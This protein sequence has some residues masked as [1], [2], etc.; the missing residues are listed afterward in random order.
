MTGILGSGFGLYGYLPAVVR[1]G[2]EKVVL[3]SKAREVFLRRPE[4]QFCEQ[5]I[6]WV[7]DVRDLM[8]KSSSV[9]FAVTPSAQSSYIK[10]YIPT[11]K[12]D[13]VILEKPIGVSPTEAAI[14]LSLLAGNKISTRIGYTFLY[15]QW[16]QETIRYLRNITAGA[17][18]TL[19]WNFLAHHYKND[20]TS[21]K[22]YNREG[23][24]V[25]RFYGTQVL[26][27]LSVAG[28]DEVIKSE[29]EGLTDNDLYLWRAS[30]SGPNL[31]R[32]DISINCYSNDERFTIFGSDKNF[33]GFDLV[34]PF[35]NE[36]MGLPDRR[37]GTLGSVLASFEIENDQD[38]FKSYNKTN[39]LWKNVEEKNVVTFKPH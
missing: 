26:A 11:R 8:Q 30:F 37:L 19:T 21:W 22:R 10:E 4:L 38:A 25:L 27:F 20:S 34:D 3:L 14:V 33:H 35:E 2:K 39:D 29:C 15:T 7:Q 18:F 6:E 23:G 9:I 16:A 1:A 5:H 24:G 12:F 36:G 17:P 32:F 31:P 28:Y 13:Q